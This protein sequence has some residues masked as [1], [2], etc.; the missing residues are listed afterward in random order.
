MPVPGSEYLEALISLLS[1]DS[2]SSTT[3]SLIL[4]TMP[5]RCAAYIV[6]QLPKFNITKILQQ[7]FPGC[8]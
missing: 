5:G 7:L 3:A 8:H 6:D 1:K 4:A 2:D